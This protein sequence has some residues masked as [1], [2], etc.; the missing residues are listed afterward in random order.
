ME[1]SMEYVK[2][3][4]GRFWAI[5]EDKGEPYQRMVFYS[6]DYKEVL[7]VYRTLRGE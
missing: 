2:G 7:S 1:Y 5:Y 6:K 3:L 4:F